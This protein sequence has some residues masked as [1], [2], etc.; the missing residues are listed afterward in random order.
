MIQEKR[1]GNVVLFNSYIF[2]LVFLPLSV[3]GYFILNRI[4]EKGALLYLLLMSLWFYG[5]FNYKY[6]FIII[7]SIIVNYGFAWAMNKEALKISEN[8]DGGHFFT[9]PPIQQEVSIYFTIPCSPF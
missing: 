9:P 3:I 6:L 7:S 5:Y 4:A 8:T 2:I 1:G